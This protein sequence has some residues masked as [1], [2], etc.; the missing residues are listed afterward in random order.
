MDTTAKKQTRQKGL[1]KLKSKQRY[2]KNRGKSKAK[3]RQRY[4]KVRKQPSFKK[5][6]RIRRKKPWLSKR[7]RAEESENSVQ[8]QDISFIHPDTGEAVGIEAIDPSDYTI[9]Y[10]DD[11]GEMGTIDIED[12]IDRAEFPSWDDIEEFYDVL[13]DIFLSEEEDERFDNVDLEEALEHGD[14]PDEEKLWDVI[15]RV[16]RRQEMIENV[17]RKYRA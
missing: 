16:A 11:D 17:V 13:D 1:A 2:I 4:R 5:K 14:E 10:V 3:S 12:V 6:Q 9:K 7:K 15:D 8:P